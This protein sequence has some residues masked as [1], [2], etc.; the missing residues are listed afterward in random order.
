MKRYFTLV[1]I[2]FITLSAFAQ[3]RQITGK[4]T[5][6]SG[7]GLPGVTIQLLGTTSGTITDANG[8][9]KIVADKGTLRFS[10]PPCRCHYWYVRSL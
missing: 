1:L 6:A 8:D 3:D 10:Y 5:D 9:Y 7:A 4:V 2:T